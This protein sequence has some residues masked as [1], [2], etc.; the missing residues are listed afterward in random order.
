MSRMRWDKAAETARGR[1]YALS[2]R[3][4]QAKQAR[5]R[6]KALL[7]AATPGAIW[8]A[9]V[10]DGVNAD[11]SLRV[12]VFANRKEADDAGYPWVGRVR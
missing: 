7:E 2:S 10:T 6:R 9:Y 1:T 11:G 3:A 12:L 5:D 8:P 4:K